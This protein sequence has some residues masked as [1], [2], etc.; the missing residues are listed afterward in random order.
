VTTVTDHLERRG[1][2]F[3]VLFH[4]PTTTALAEARTLG[5]DPAEVVK[6]VLL[7]VDTGH[8]LA[9]LPASRRLD[10]RLV[11]EALDAPEAELADEEE[12][13]ADY[14]QF[15]LGALPALPSLLHV[16][17]V[18]D[19][20]VFEHRTVTLAAGTRRES[21]RLSN[22]HLLKGATVTIATIS[23]SPDELRWS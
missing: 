22:E 4:E 16:P 1:V 7:D 14:P 13:E 23:R 17:V 21:V 8:A 15:E 2:E 9:V 5:R 3:E 10:L 6:A 11:R 20:L 12:I 19:P 18:I